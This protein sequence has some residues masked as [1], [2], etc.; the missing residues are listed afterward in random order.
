MQSAMALLSEISSHS[1]A[2]H[3]RRHEPIWGNDDYDHPVGGTH[4]TDTDRI[5]QLYADWRKAVESA[6]IPGYVRV[7]HD[8]V[9]LMPPGAA[10][11]Q[12]AAHYARFL[13]PVFDTATYRIEVVSPPAV[14]V[15]GDVA[16]A[17]YEYVIHLKLK[18]AGQA[19]TEPGALTAS[20]TASRYFDVLRRRPDGGWAVWKHTWNASP[21]G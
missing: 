18:N 16:V 9:T 15:L 13:G 3:Q 8:D 10:D 5:A 11:I 19:V 17:R 21:E 7:L 1:Q 6:D 4:V 12:G 14:E 20:R 2:L